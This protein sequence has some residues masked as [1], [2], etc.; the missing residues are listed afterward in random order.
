M[1]RNLP[2]SFVPIV[3]RKSGRLSHSPAGRYDR[4]GFAD[5][6]DSDTPSDDLTLAPNRIGAHPSDRCGPLRKAR[7]ALRDEAKRIP[8]PGAPVGGWHRRVW[9]L[10]G[11]IMV[12][13]LS[14]PLLGAVDTA[15]VGRLPDAAY[16]GGVAIGA[17]I[18][19]FLFWGFGFLRMG[20]TGFTAQA[21]GAGD[22]DELRAA[23][24]RPLILA[25][26]FGAA[27]IAL[28]APIALV[29]FWIL[30]ASPEV[31]AFAGAYYA[32]RIWSAPAALIN[33]TVIGWLFGTHRSGSRHRSG[34]SRVQ[35]RSARRRKHDAQRAAAHVV[36]VRGTDR[37]AVVG[38][39]G[40]DDHGPGHVQK[41]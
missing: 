18:F 39:R 16:I 38:A 10:A 11:P 1:V 13:N 6:A 15:V 17:V 36:V 32:I 8:L 29:A 21:F 23:L 28:Q 9:W 7:S 34:S 22:A 41:D 31:E 30:E 33:C 40:G 27:L 3:Y 5:W 2:V 35:V 25:C 4:A 14:T 26:A 24:V 19:N 12:S 20:T 37:R